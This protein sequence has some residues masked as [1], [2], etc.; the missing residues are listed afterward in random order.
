[1]DVVV[2]GYNCCSEAH[3]LFEQFHKCSPM[4]SL[5]E[6]LA[7]A[8]PKDV[9]LSVRHITCPP[10]PCEPIFSPPLGEDPEPTSCENHFLAV[11]IKP[12]GAVT[13]TDNNDELLVF[14]IEVLVYTTARLTTVFVSKAD[15]TGYLYLLNQP[16]AKSLTRSAFTVFLSHLVRAYQRPRIRLV[17]CLFA[18]AQNQ[19]LFP[20]SIEN[21][22]KHVLD[23]RGLIKWWCRVFDPILRDFEPEK[24]A[25]NKLTSNSK[26]STGAEVREATSTAYLIV[27]GCDKY[28]TR[29]FFPPTAKLDPQDKP[30]WLN[31]YP[32]H[33]IC[34]TPGAPPRCLVPRFPD[35]PK[36]R[37]L[38]EL[39]EEIFGRPPPY[40]SRGKK[41]KSTVDDIID[42]TATPSREQAAPGQWLSVKSLEEFWEMMTFR[43]ECSAGRLV[44]F[45]WMIIN[46]PGVL[47]SDGLNQDDLSKENNQSEEVKMLDSNT[48]TMANESTGSIMPNSQTVSCND[49]KTDQ[50]A[51]STSS[52][53][54]LDNK[55]SCQVKDSIMTG[56]ENQVSPSCQNTNTILLSTKHYSTLSN[57]L[58]KLDFA[59][60]A[61]ALT[62]TKSWLDKL[63]SLS[64]H[65]THGEIVIGV[66]GPSEQPLASLQ[67]QA[68]P[69]S[70]LNSGLIVKKRKR[71]TGTDLDATSSQQEPSATVNVLNATLIRKKKKAG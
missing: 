51:D 28:E 2:D 40:P 42:D 45:L 29:A 69:S 25:T 26:E 52:N 62:S 11:S 71:H 3:H 30:R 6:E 13:N 20:G 5:A 55:N 7:Q 36:A 56:T 41:Y 60:Q 21:P 50:K 64:G 65:K 54:A 1:M 63:S 34:A 37:F 68:D 49:I 19:Y 35:D 16:T 48:N 47:K 27:P 15:S 22:H 31:N 24:Q 9:K 53:N 4:A 43:Q 32:L 67:H 46:P 58:L 12:E 8:L 23:D 59:D 57:F 33:Q 39:D 66:R 10:A 44:G 70:P 17:L 18:R 38:D 14:S 61:V